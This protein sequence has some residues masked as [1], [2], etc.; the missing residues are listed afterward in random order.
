M[1]VYEHRLHPPGDESHRFRFHPNDLLRA[2]LDLR[3]VR[4]EEPMELSENEMGVALVA[5]KRA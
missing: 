3:I 4:Y 5:R 2:C 1:L